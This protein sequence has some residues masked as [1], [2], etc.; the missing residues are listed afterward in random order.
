MTALRG[1]IVAITLVTVSPVFGDT[2]T[3]TNTADSGPGSLRDAIATAVA[4]DT[5]AINVL[6]T[7]TLTS[8]TLS[9]RKDLTIVGPGS[10]KVVIDGTNLSR[11]FT[12]ADVGTAT[13]LISGVTIQNGSADWG[14]GIVNGGRLTLTDTVI[15]G[16]TATV[17]GGGIVNGGTLTLATS[18]VMNNAAGGGCGGIANTDT[19]ILT[20]SASTVSGN[21]AT[22]GGGGICNND[23]T[24]TVTDSTLS[25]NSSGDG[26]G[27]YNGGF[28]GAVI[29]K[30]S[31]ISGNY[32][33]DEGGAMFHATG[34]LTLSNST[35]ANNSA[36]H[37]GGGIV[38]LQAWALVSNGTFYANSEGSLATWYGS[39]RVRNSILANSGI[40][41]INSILGGIVSEGHNLSDDVSCGS[42]FTDPSDL[43]FTPA[44]LSPLG[45]AD[46]GGLTET[47]TLLS[48]SPAVDSVPLAACTDPTGA[49]ATDQRGI[50]RP[51]GGACDIGAL[52]LI[53]S[54]FLARIAT[55]VKADGTSVFSANRGVVPVK[56]TLAF[57]GSDTCQ[58]PVATISV[59]RTVGAVVGAVNE[60][61]Y[62]L[63]SDIG[64][65][66]RVDT[67]ACQYVYNLGTSSLG[68]GTYSVYI[69]IDRVFVGS[70]V[71]GLK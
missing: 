7:I 17:N 64:T 6:G 39:T 44:G 13:V 10:E 34:T 37:G 52:E 33:V 8:G 16:N 2:L 30:N 5:I 14:G 11:V 46:N 3:V 32:A 69:S 67:V 58:L 45:L 49:V 12:I 9:I 35:I 27:I 23:G 19:A 66:F 26:G 51:Q 61:S 29:V 36:S 43:N 56:F 60:D 18:Q 68:A 54:P 31:T 50:A 21:N 57:E 47:I 62:M 59:Y 20:I 4:G 42:A 22:F 71:F 63:G 28:G 38:N 15:A 25:G 40:N 41:C 55:P 24:L 65:N 70:A 48:T 53:P 1:F